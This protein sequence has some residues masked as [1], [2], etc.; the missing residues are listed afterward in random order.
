ME[1]SVTLGGEN[2]LI[3]TVPGQPE[4]E[5]VP[6]KGTTYNLKNLQGFSIK[7]KLD[8]SGNVY[9]AELTQPNGIFAAKKSS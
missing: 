3:V 5:L 9:E 2:T 4:L 6:Y 8:D 7:F 1:L